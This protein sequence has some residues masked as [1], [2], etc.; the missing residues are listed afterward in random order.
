[1]MKNII[2]H[3]LDGKAEPLRSGQR[4]QDVGQA[5]H[6]RSQSTLNLCQSLAATSLTARRHLSSEKIKWQ[7]QLKSRISIL[8]Q[9]KTLLKT[10]NTLKTIIKTKKV[11]ICKFFKRQSQKSMNSLVLGARKP[12]EFISHVSNSVQTLTS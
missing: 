3:R 9:I 1:M 12:G 8:S 2:C 10:K 11:I 5:T 4:S 6:D 7:S